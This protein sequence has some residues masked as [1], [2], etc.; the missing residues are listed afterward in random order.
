MRSR[1]W[2]ASALYVANA[3]LSS[4]VQKRFP[5]SKPLSH[6]RG[7][8]STSKAPFQQIT[9]T[10]TSSWLLMST[11]GSHSSS[12]VL[13][14][15]QTQLLSALHC[16]FHLLECQH[17]STLTAELHLW[18]ESYANSCLQKGWFRVKLPVTTQ[19]KTVKQRGAMAWYGKL[20]LWVGNPRTFH[21]RIGKMSS[22]M[23]C[24]PFAPFC[25]APP[26]KL[27]MSDSLVSHANR[28]LPPPFP[29]G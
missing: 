23:C 17:M 20:L 27:L 12:H 7:S 6:L 28:P 13:M 26:M 8:I 2:Q 18:V 16:F 9:E 29:P 25:V 24:T 10:G 1:K 11:P 14:C 21:L 3:D 5:L 19:K 4:I 22:L 15:L